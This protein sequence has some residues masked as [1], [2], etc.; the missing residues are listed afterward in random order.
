MKPAPM[1]PAA[2][3]FR[4]SLLDCLF[5]ISMIYL[6]VYNLPEQA[7]KITLIFNTFIPPI[8]S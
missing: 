2:V 1:A 5:F 3:S 4:K 8:H 6:K 7:I